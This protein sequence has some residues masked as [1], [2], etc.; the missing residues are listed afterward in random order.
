MPL[1]IVDCHSPN[2]VEEGLATHMMTR[3]ELSKQIS[4][5]KQSEVGKHVT[6]ALL[7]VSEFNQGVC[8]GGGG[9]FPA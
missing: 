8:G 1:Q 6:D 7:S 4:P 9:G 5:N 2:L 3:I